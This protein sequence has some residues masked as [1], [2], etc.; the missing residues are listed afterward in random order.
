MTTGLND[1]GPGGAAAADGFP[2]Y[3]PVDAALGYLL[4][5]VVVDRATP[6]VLSVAGDV[7]P[8]VASSAVGFALAA[9]LWF[10]L[11]VTALEQGRRQAVAAGLVG[12]D[13]GTASVW[14]SVLP[15]ETT[16]QFYLA[17]LVVSGLVA[18]WTFETALETLVSL[19]RIVAALDVAALDLV[20]LLVTAVFFLAYETATVSLDRLLVG[21]VRRLFAG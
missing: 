14:P 2:A 1:G 11:G 10:V 20:A 17:L 6:T 12:G 19:V 8:D 3:G 5:Y 7:F 9:F 4:F 16:D 18:G 21:T 15:A 13:A